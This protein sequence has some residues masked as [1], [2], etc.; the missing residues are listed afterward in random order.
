MCATDMDGTKQNNV[1]F[2]MFFLCS[3]SLFPEVTCDKPQIKHAYI[4]EGKSTSYGYKSSVRV[5]CNDG[6]MMK[7]S[8]NLT[9]EEDGWNPPPPQCH[10]SKINQ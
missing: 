3:S 9:C 1:L 2:L 5:R 4:I 8:D 7:G 6:Y 10:L